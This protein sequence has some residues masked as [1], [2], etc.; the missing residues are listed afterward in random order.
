MLTCL[1]LFYK[2]FTCHL[3]TH[4]SCNPACWNPAG[5]AHR[6]PGLAQNLTDGCAVGAEVK[7]EKSSRK[8]RQE[9]NRSS[10]EKETFPFLELE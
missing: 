10:G 2:Y 1:F 3:A 7:L 9:V 8:W 4:E 6:E 5:G